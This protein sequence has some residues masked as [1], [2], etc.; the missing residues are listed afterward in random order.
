MVGGVGKKTNQSDV[1]GKLRSTYTQV[2]WYRLAMR[3][4]ANTGEEEATGH[5]D[6]LHI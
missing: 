5:L 6:V 2:V 4:N 1:V 3:P